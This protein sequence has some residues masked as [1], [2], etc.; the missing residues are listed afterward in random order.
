MC[1]TDATR[2]RRNSH[3]Y[4]SERTKLHNFQ[5]TT[6]S[7]ADQQHFS[8][9]HGYPSYIPQVFPCT[10]NL[11]GLEALRR[12]L[13]FSILESSHDPSLISTTL[14]GQSILRSMQTTPAEV[15]CAPVQISEPL[16]SFYS[17]LSNVRDMNLTQ[18]S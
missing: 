9:V 12:N 7:V 5:K 14:F 11:I 1:K 3:E 18:I 10:P 4:T 2:A 6:E 8:S 16:S 17:L 15:F 13:C